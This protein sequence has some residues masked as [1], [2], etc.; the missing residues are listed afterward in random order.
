MFRSGAGRLKPVA[1]ADRAN[2]KVKR[3]VLGM[4]AI[5]KQFIVCLVRGANLGEIDLMGSLMVL[6]E[7]SAKSALSFV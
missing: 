5:I 7:M 1:S 2:L 6:A 4:S 3:R